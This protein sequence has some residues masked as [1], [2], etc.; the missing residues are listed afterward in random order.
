MTSTKDWLHQTTLRKLHT[1]TFSQKKTNGELVPGKYYRITDYVT[2]TTQEGTQSA[3]HQFDI[4]VLALDDHTLSNDAKAALHEGD[5]YFSGNNCKLESWELKYTT[6]NDTEKLAWAQPSEKF[7]YIGQYSTYIYSDPEDPTSEI[8]GVDT[9]SYTGVS[10]TRF[11]YAG[12][13]QIDE[14]QTEYDVF[15]AED[16]SSAIALPDG[17]ETF[18]DTIGNNPGENPLIPRKFFNLESEEYSPY[19]A[20]VVKICEDGGKG[21]IYYMKDEWNNECPYDFKNIQFTRKMTDGEF[22]ATNGVDTYVYTFT[23][24]DE[25]GKEPEIIDMSVLNRDLN[26]GFALCLC[27]N[28]ISNT[29]SVGN[30]R[31]VYELRNNV[32]ICNAE[33]VYHTAYRIDKNYIGGDSYDNTFVGNTIMNRLGDD[34][35]SNVFYWSSGNDLTHCSNCTLGKHSNDNTIF[36]SHHITLNESNT[37]NRISNSDA[38]TFDK[39]AT[40]YVEIDGCIG[41]ILTT[42]MTTL[43]ETHHWLQNIKVLTG[44]NDNTVNVKTITH[45]TID[46]VGLTIYRGN[47]VREVTV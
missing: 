25:T 12:T 34:C 27:D 10:Q 20:P 42:P 14:T 21:V 17:T 3:G 19:L 47:N 15:V 5:T 7:L 41:L 22:D 46:D 37:D 6:E 36:N 30:Y 39:V 26:G 1:L 23:W 11:K 28:E 38:I 13:G 33:D 31:P 44:T 16:F 24:V 8:V 29:G 18:D 32:F 43:P 9:T 4:I 35:N 40:R 45:P 2:T